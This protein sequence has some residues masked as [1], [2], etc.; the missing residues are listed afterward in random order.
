MPITPQDSYLVMQD[1][2][3]Q[4]M[5]SKAP[6]TIDETNFLD[7]GDTVATY[8]QE[9]VFNAVHMSLGR[10]VM[11]VRSVDEEFNIIGAIDTSEYNHRFRKISFYSKKTKPSGMFNTN[12]Y[13]NHKTGYTAGTNG[14][15]STPSQ[16][17]QNLAI[18][19]EMNFGKSSTWQYCVTNLLIDGKYAFQN[20]S[21]WVAFIEGYMT[22]HA[23]DMKMEREAFKRMTFA[24]HI[25][26][27]YA[28]GTSTG[29]AASLGVRNLTKEFNDKFGTAYTSAQ[30]RTTYLKE[31]LEFFTATVK[32]DSKKMRRNNVLYHY[33]PVITENGETFHLPRH[34]PARYQKMVMLDEFWIDAQAQVM[35]EIFNTEYLDKGNFETIEYWQ[36]PLAPAEIDMTVPIPAWLNTIMSG[37]TAQDTT[38]NVNISYFLGAIF[39][40]DACLVDMQVERAN[41]TPV[42]A[43]KGFSNTWYTFAKNAICDPTEKT[44]IYVMED[45]PANVTITPTL[46]SVTL[47]G[48]KVASDLQSDIVI[49]SNNVAHGTL[50]YI[51]GGL[52]ESG[53][54][55]G[56]GYFMALSWSAPGDTVTSL[57]VGLT[58]SQGTGLVDALGDPDRTVVCKITNK[59]IQN[60]TLVQSDGDTSNVQYVYLGSLNLE[61][62]D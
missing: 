58:N 45:G 46:D 17:E 59:D 54:L 43:R 12:L 48:G 22:Q 47:Y 37:Q 4:I 39:D 15:E 24:G 28:A 53:P 61:P 50:K 19:L 26:V 40:R 3:D 9:I 60:F 51:E 20:E 30:L 57:R 56:S 42:E 35:P 44:I 36:S 23:N 38:A 34:T 18:P 41:T 2:V 52:A 14:G 1:M 7:V 11:A 25:A 49:D 33:Y 5:G 8:S 29:G 10:F 27:N 21:E 16:W 32:K 31:F 13:T 6:D 55:A 62:H